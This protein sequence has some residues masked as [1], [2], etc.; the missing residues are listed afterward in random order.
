MPYPVQ[1][2]LHGKG[3][4]RRLDDGNH[5]IDSRVDSESL[6]IMPRQRSLPEY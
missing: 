3:C 5:Q 1:L 6:D 4:P 2:I